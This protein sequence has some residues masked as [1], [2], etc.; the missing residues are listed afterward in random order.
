VHVADLAPLY[1][2]V[3]LAAGARAD[4][5]LGL[6]GEGALAGVFGARDFV[7]WYNGAPDMAGLTAALGLHA[8]RDVV[9]IGQGNVAIDCAR[10]LCKT[11]AELAGSDVAAHAAHALAASAVRRVHLV[12]RRGHVQ[13]SFTMKELREVTRLAD[14][15]FVVRPGELAA[16]RTPASLAEAA[17]SRARARMD[18]LL[19]EAAAAPP[20]SPPA[21]RELH[22]RFLL[23]PTALLPA[24]GAGAGAGGAP[25]RVGA[26]QF[27][28]TRLEGA[29]DAQRAVPTGETATLAADLVLR[30][31]GYSST[32]LHGVPFDDRRKVVHNE[33]GRVLAEPADGG[34]PLPGLYVSGWLKRGPTGIIGTNI[35]DA[36][37]TVAAIVEDAAAGRLRARA[38]AAAGG[39]SALPQLRAL[40][41]ARGGSADETVDWDGFCRIDA[42]EVARGAAV[43]KP[44]EKFVALADMLQA[45]RA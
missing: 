2:A 4:R 17:A 14:A 45:A 1:D 12:G 8:V 10:L 20:R 21:S 23:A 39:G 3:V 29:A 5:S 6:P 32:P 16:G 25:P 42:A 26:V 7:A 27:A 28:V 24:A 33:R 18:A 35:P 43:G 41:A 30:S 11:R 36:K 40:L 13:A 38:G 37:E 22:A 9:I 31:V 15:A 44:R 34:A 19:G